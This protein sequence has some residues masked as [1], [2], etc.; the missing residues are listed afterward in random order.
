MLRKILLALLIV[1][2]VVQFIQPPLNKGAAS[3]ANDITSAVQVPD[4]IMSLLKNACYDCHSNFTKYPWYSKITPINWW[5]YNHVKEGKQHLNFSAF[6]GT[7][8][9]KM[10]KLEESA[11]LVEKHEM[12][13][14]S[15]LW[16]HTEA[17]LSQQQRQ[18]IIDWC[19]TSREKLMQDSLIASTRP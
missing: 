17:G 1:L 3:T 6:T 19:N 14:E 18:M 8:K 4:T 10:R 12:P 11:E 15:Y 5:L 13:M 9:R 7:Y 16:M 2:I